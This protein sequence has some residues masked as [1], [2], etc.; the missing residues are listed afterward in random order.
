[1]VKASR[2]KQRNIPFHRFA[3]ELGGGLAVSETADISCFE[4]AAPTGPQPTAPALCH[5]R[6]VPVAQISEIAN[7]RGRIAHPRQCRFHLEKEFA[8]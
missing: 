5:F 7:Y 8:A 3:A 6:I 2:G 4:K 1:M